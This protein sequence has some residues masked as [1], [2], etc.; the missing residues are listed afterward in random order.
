M[1]TRE[2]D[3]VRAIS[4]RNEGR[5]WREIGV[6]LAGE[7]KRRSP[8][9]PRSVTRA[10]KHYERRWA[11][12]T[13]RTKALDE[14]MMKARDRVA[15]RQ[16][17]IGSLDDPFRDSDMLAMFDAIDAVMEHLASKRP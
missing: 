8:F 2:L 11:E 4:L 13:S 17:E 10:I 14:V 15:A 1:R 7:I 9:E 6:I 16:D 3:P 12:R 5:S